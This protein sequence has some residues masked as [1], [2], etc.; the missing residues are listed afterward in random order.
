VH[1]LTIPIIFALALLQT[2]PPASNAARH[3][4]EH[5][6]DSLAVVQKNIAAKKAVLV[7]VRSQEEWNE[8]HI[9][10]SI[11]VP[12]TSLRQGGDPKELAKK[13]PKKK[14]LYTY[15]VVGMRAKNAAIAL[16]K[17]GYT[18]RPLKP[19]YEQL[20][21]AGFKKAGSKP[22]AAPAAPTAPN[23]PAATPDAG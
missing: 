3:N 12:I 4:V 1:A 17:H 9:A 8:G 19:G 20:L 11:F 15:C 22:A 14:I 18:V 21:K 2:A 7:D 23:P 13:L 10:G 6:K 5:T 16:Q